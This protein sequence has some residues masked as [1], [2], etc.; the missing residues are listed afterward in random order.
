M[1]ICIYNSDNKLRKYIC[2]Y[3]NNKT[4][5]NVYKYKTKDRKKAME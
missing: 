1:Y 5:K 3:K 2:I 4:M